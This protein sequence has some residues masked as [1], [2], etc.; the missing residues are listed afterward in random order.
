[1]SRQAKKWR[2]LP[3]DSVLHQA[4]VDLTMKALKGELRAPYGMEA[5]LETL[6][7]ALMRTDKPSV[8]VTGEPGVGKS[9]MPESLA[10]AQVAGQL[11]EPL[12]SR[13]LVSISPQAIHGL[14]RRDS[15]VNTHLSI[16][17]E[18]LLEARRWN[19]ILVFDELGSVLFF[20]LSMRMM[21][22]GLARGE[23]SVIGTLTTREWHRVVAMEPAL[24]R[25]FQ[26]VHIPEPRGERLLEILRYVAGTLEESRGVVI[27]E[28]VI[29]EC[30][31]RS[32]FLGTEPDSAISLLQSSAIL[33]QQR[34][35]STEGA[36]PS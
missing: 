4:G 9:T 25:R 7:R 15:D 22:P 6:V 12:S 33:A 27:S 14:Q 19:I 1:M 17:K 26:E 16:W 28:H 32:R 24:A 10:I 18:M 2:E 20:P 11:P 29:R 3:E 5:Y 31:R 23:F 36:K 8:V 21:L 30:A 13:R 34:V 35:L